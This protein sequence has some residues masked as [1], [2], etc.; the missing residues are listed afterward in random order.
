MFVA[1][2]PGARLVIVDMMPHRTRTRPRADQTKNHVLA[3]E[4]T[5]AELR[6]AGFAILER[7]DGFVDNADSESASW[8]LVAQRPSN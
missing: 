6:G 5:E 2:K 3:P 7:R 4:I 8:L 1:L